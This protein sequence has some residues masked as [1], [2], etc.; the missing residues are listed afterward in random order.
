VQA[1]TAG[2]AIRVSLSAVQRFTIGAAW[3]SHH[4]H[5]SSDVS[6][7]D[8]ASVRSPVTPRSPRG[9][10]RACR[11]DGKQSSRVAVDLYDLGLH[12]MLRSSMA[13]HLVNQ[14]IGSPGR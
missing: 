5:A 1:L 12:L 13:I 14:R 11:G 10:R 9:G 6:T 8:R 4:A 2:S 3:V 7:A